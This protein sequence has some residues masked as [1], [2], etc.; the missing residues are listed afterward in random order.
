MVLRFSVSKQLWLVEWLRLQ[1]HRQAILRRFH[2]GGEEVTVEMDLIGCVRVAIVVR[3]T[4]IDKV[5]T[6]RYERES[7]LLGI[8]S[9]VL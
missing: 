8:I 4:I 3:K 9:R 5:A 2:I 7:Y 1:R 6:D